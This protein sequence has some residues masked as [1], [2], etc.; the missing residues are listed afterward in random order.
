MGTSSSS[1]STSSSSSSCK[2]LRVVLLVA[3]AVAAAVAGE[4]EQAPEAISYDGRSLLINGQRRML[5]SGSI[6]YPR[7]TPQM[8]PDLIAKAKKGGL[9]VIQTYVFWNLHEPVPRQYYFEENCDLVVFLKEVQAQGF[10]GPTTNLSNS[11]WSFTTKIV[12]LMKSEKLYASQG[13]PINM[14]QIE[15]EY[16]T[17]EMGYHKAGAAYMK[18]AAQMVVGLDTGV[19]WIMCKQDDALDPVINTCN[20]LNCGE[21]I[22]W[23]KLT[24]EPSSVDR[25][26]DFSIPS[27]GS[28]VDYYMYYGGTNFGR[29]SLS[30]VTTSYYDDAPINEYGLV[31]QPKWGH[32]K[33]L[34]SAI[35]LYEAPLLMGTPTYSSLGQFQEVYIFQGKAKGCVAFL[36]NTDKRNNATVHFHGTSYDLPAHSISILGDCKDETYN[37]A[38]VNTQLNVRSHVSSSKISEGMYGR[39]EPIPNYPDLGKRGFG[40]D[41]D[42]TAECS[43]S[44]LHLRPISLFLLLL[45]QQRPDPD[46]PIEEGEK[47][48]VKLELAIRSSSFLSRVKL[49][50]AKLGLDCSPSLEIVWLIIGFIVYPSTRV[51]LTPPLAF[52]RSVSLEVPVHSAIAATSVTISP[53]KKNSLSSATLTMK[54]SPAG[55]WLPD[56]PAGG[57]WL[58]KVVVDSAI[59]ATFATLS[60]KRKW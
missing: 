30:C 20:G 9:D 8:W 34:H 60:P 58:S 14:S 41:E 24:Y 48:R 51:S 2:A 27:N 42:P 45:P 59:G 39:M 3:A 53:K 10:S 28:F 19:P 7:S 43:S 55:R 23:P 25:E 17:Y 15:N 54:R 37:T 18:R 6:H 56:V 22:C 29:K 16:G 31:R 35:K 33:D 47:S 46:M 26:L 40:E 21:T 4:V 38:K 13:G 12:Q 11:T 1:P 32:L 50:L 52:P 57:R 49:E 5:F 36:V 44:I